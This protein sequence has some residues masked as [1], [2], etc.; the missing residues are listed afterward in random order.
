MEAESILFE[1]G[2]GRLPLIVNGKGQGFHEPVLFMKLERR[3]NYT[4]SVKL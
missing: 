3:V 2:L 1:S 4:N